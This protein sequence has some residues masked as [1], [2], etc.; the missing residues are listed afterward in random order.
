MTYE[1]GDELTGTFQDGQLNEEF[2]VMYRWRDGTVFNGWFRNNQPNK[3][4]VSHSNGE[5]WEI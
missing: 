3:G 1:N 2:V 4:S 5:K